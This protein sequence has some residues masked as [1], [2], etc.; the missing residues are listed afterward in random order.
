MNSKVDIQVRAMNAADWRDLQAGSHWEN[1]G[2]DLKHFTGIAWYRVDVQV[3]AD[4][5]GL[6]ARAVFEGVDDSFECW[7]NGKSVG[8]FGDPETETTIWLERQVAD[9][10]G[11]LRPGGVNTIVLRVVDHAGAGGLWKPV[12]LTT[13]PVG[14]H[15]R[16]LH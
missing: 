6:N 14:V 10:A 5:N 12:F 7:V 2:E 3:P 9:L 8:R 13:G 11:A 1:Q 15:S 16:L 4:W